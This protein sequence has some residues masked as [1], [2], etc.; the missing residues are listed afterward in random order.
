MEEGGG[1]ARRWSE[2]EKG[3]GERVREREKECGRVKERWRESEGK[4]E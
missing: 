2:S 1:I 3:E 4:R